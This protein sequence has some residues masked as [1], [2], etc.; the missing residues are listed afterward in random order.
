MTGCVDEEA[1]SNESINETSNTT[2]GNVTE[3]MYA[4]DVNTAGDG[5]IDISPDQ[6]EYEEGTNVVITATPGSGYD[7]QEWAGDY[8]GTEKE[9]TVTMD[10]DKSITA[11]FTE[12]TEV[13]DSYEDQ[14]YDVYS[15]YQMD[16][17]TERQSKMQTCYQGKYYDY[18]VD[19]ENV[20]HCNEIYPS[21][22]LATC[23]AYYYQQTGEETC[24]DIPVEYYE[25]QGY[26]DE[27][28]TKDVCYAN[29]VVLEV[30][31]N[32]YSTPESFFD[33]NCGKIEN[34]QMKSSCWDM[35]SE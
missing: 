14:C 15:S 21:Y 4:L 1:M 18:A 19:H 17:T 28:N 16:P 7:F 25:A 12:E 8:E 24:K 22:R 32:P 29:Y 27:I 34:E 2:E 31:E 35:Y 13:K 5:S 3:E 20:S 33:E 6:E 30:S 11:Q 26:Y 10:E 23:Y 9:I